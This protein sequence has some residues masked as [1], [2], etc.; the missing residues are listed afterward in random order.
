MSVEGSA[1]VVGDEHSST[2]AETHAMAFTG[3]LDAVYYPE[4]ED[5]AFR[6]AVT[7]G[8]CLLTATAIFNGAPSLR[9]VCAAPL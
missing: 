3:V 9:L 8:T 1:H 6:A 4:S 5:A 7:A 2:A